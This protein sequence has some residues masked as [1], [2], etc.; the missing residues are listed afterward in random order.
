MKK[1]LILSVTLIAA[2]CG[3]RSPQPTFY[4]LGDVTGAVSDDARAGAT[5]R[6]VD[7]GRVRIPEYIDRPQMVTVRDVYVDVAADH[8]WAEGLSPMIQRRLIT[9][10]GTQLENAVVKDATFG[11]P[12]GDCVVMVEIYRL[13]GQLGTSVQMDAVY[14]VLSDG[15]TGRPQTVH[16]SV[17]VGDTYGDYATAVGRLVDQLSGDVARDVGRLKR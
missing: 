2:A 3:G 4:R 1:Y 12:S 13:D 17:P 14:D 5:P 6:R 11:G 10:L 9:N 16:Y 7:V 15:H 8:R